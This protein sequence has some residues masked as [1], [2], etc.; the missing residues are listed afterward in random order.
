M[1]ENAQKMNK[2]R[3]EIR[4]NVEITTVDRFEQVMFANTKRQNVDSRCRE[5]CTHKWPCDDDGNGVSGRATRYILHVDVSVYFPFFILLLPP[6]PNSPP[7]SFPLSLLLSLSVSLLS[8]FASK[9]KYILL[10]FAIY[11]KHE[12]AA[13]SVAA[14]RSLL[15]VSVCLHRA[16]MP[17]RASTATER[18]DTKRRIFIE[19][20]LKSKISFSSSHQHQLSTRVDSFFP[21]LFLRSF[22]LFAGANLFKLNF[23]ERDGKCSAT[24]RAGCEGK[25]ARR[26]KCRSK[27]S[28]RKTCE[29]K[30]S[31]GIPRK[32]LL[33]R[34]YFYHDSCERFSLF[35]FLLAKVNVSLRLHGSERANGC[36]SESG[37]VC[38]HFGSFLCL[39]CAD[40]LHNW[41]SP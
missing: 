24:V 9:G 21:S 8:V 19:I 22:F 26:K 35:V 13:S 33:W 38:F 34:H 20:K 17:K 6:P 3:R 23:I 39:R 7:L 18:F 28:E 2:E 14:N 27:T 36:E 15:Y 41:P 10:P 12:S 5:T 40:P 32:K 25:R 16:M 4:L 1:D 37:S 11:I 30:S 31:S 29:Y